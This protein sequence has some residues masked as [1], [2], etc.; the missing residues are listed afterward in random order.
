MFVD[1]DDG[2][3]GGASKPFE[4]LLYGCIEFLMFVFDFSFLDDCS[5]ESMEEAF[6]KLDVNADDDDDEDED[7]EDED[8]DEHT[9]LESTVLANEFPRLF[10]DCLDGEDFAVVI[11]TLFLIEEDEE[12]DKDEDEFVGS[13][14]FLTS[15]EKDGDFLR[16][17]DGNT[18]L[19][20][21]SF[22]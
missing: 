15:D 21:V 17:E 13:L 19:L 3:G 18:A 1:D 12:F 9:S 8:D 4:L 10:F 16:F 14:L 11:F 22:L 2:G 6:F 5:N 20:F 7:E